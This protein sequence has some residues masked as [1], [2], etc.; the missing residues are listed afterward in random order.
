MKV[1]L[2]TESACDFSAVLGT[3][4]AEIDQMTMADAIDCDLSVYDAYCVLPF[5]KLLDARLRERLENE[6]AK[7]KRI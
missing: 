7:G 5:G 6:N 4:G 1:L 3:C 2:L